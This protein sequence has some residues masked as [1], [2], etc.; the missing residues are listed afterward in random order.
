MSTYA[1]SIQSSQTLVNEKAP[2]PS[3]EVAASQDGSQDLKAFPQAPAQPTPFRF[4][5]NFGFYH[6]SGSFS[7][8]VIASQKDDPNPLFYIS[9]HGGFSSQPS[10]VLHS[11]RFSTS[12][13]LATAD[14]HSFS[15]TIDMS[16]YLPGSP[17]QISSME[18][19]GAFTYTRRFSARM[20]SGGKEAFEWKNSQ[21]VEVQSLH[22]RGHGKKCIRV[23]TG[24]VVAAFTHPD[25]SRNKKGK[26]AF[27]GD[28]AGLGEGFEVLCVM[29]MLAIM[30]KERRAKR[31]RNGAVAGGAGASAGG[32]GC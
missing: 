27:L 2:P 28:R 13:P 26:M 25:M 8:L 4:P 22:G 18:S 21:G 16:L 1:F 19:S 7:D 9:T 15:S 24:E 31:S 17:N 14:F 32:G 11:S 29:A 20:P 23:A 5:Q 30:E 6:A 12:P 10:V 3:Y